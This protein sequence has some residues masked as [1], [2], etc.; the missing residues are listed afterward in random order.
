MAAG[1]AIRRVVVRAKNTLNG[2]AERQNNSRLYRA[3]VQMEIAIAEIDGYLEW[4][5]RETRKKIMNRKA[6]EIDGS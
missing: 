5:D 1:H 3:V 2:Y 4:Y 6:S